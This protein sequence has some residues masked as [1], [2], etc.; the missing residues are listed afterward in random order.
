VTI[1]LL[2][3]CKCGSV[4]SVRYGHEND[5][6]DCKYQMCKETFCFICVF[7]SVSFIEV[8]RRKYLCFAS[9]RSVEAAR[10]SVRYVQVF[11]PRGKATSGTAMSYFT[12][13][14]S[15][16]PVVALTCDTINKVHVRDSS[17][18][19]IAVLP[20][21]R[22]WT[23]SANFGNTTECCNKV[24]KDITC[25]ITVKHINKPNKRYTVYPDV[26]EKECNRKP[27]CV[28]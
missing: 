26:A 3:A 9:R 15:N 28:N 11:F 8:R 6:D 14:R 16:Y 5:D 23:F 22:I 10:L 24:L 18:H 21:L 2:C 20:V 1:E 12:C 7:I 19:C 27:P 4:R 25:L 17:V 13:C